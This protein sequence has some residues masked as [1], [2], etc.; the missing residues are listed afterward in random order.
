MTTSKRNKVT[1]LYE[2]KALTRN[3]RNEFGKW[4]TVVKEMRYRRP[5]DDLSDELRAAN[6]TID[7]F[8]FNAMAAV[9]TVFDA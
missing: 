2:T 1:D 4:E 9:L 6:L 5:V 3:E 8:I 7:I